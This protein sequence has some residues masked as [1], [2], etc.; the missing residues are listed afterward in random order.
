MDSAGEG[1]DGSGNDNNNRSA[2]STEQHNLHVTW[3]Q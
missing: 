1:R 3:I 2:S